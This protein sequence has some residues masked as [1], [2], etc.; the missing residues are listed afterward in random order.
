MV[1]KINQV[2]NNEQTQSMQ[3]QNIQAQTV[4]AFLQSKIS[5]PQTQEKIIPVFND[6]K[7]DIPENNILDYLNN[8]ILPPLLR[9]TKSLS[10]QDTKDFF[11]KEI[12]GYLTAN[13]ESIS[14]VNEVTDVSNKN[15]D[16][17]NKNT[18]VSN[19]NTESIDSF[20]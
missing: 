11:I 19:K 16:V 14:V 8:N 15:T 12:M 5:D 1:E 2:E 7:K 10:P 17:S 13:G 4:E 3:Q 6:I 9:K 18:D 20:V